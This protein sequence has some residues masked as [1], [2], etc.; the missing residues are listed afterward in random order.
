MFFGRRQ[1]ARDN[2]TNLAPGRKIFGTVQKGN[3][4]RE[5][6]PL[7]MR[8]APAWQVAAL[9]DVGRVIV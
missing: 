9:A 1:L 8:S 7:N 4:K 5:K 2:S 3:A 6:K